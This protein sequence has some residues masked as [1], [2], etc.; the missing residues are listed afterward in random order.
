M[1]HLSV[2]EYI[3][4]LLVDWLKKKINVAK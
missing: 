4:M 2:C 3:S 1:I